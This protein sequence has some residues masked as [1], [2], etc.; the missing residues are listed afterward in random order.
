MEKRE[1]KG[2]SRRRGKEGA[3]GGEREEG[4]AEG[5]EREE[6]GKDKGERKEEHIKGEENCIC[7]QL[8][9][10]IRTPTCL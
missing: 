10:S 8:H 9:F 4:G 7:Y 3:E 6:Q 5:G 1:E 2:K